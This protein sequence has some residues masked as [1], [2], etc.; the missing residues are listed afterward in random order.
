MS[1]ESG[2]SIRKSKRHDFILKAAYT[3]S[4]R[5]KILVFFYCHSN[6]IKGMADVNLSK[7]F[8]SCDLSKRLFNKR[9]RISILLYNSI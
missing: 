6:P 2:R 9:E 1:L 7:E 4:K 5:G 8:S 3:S